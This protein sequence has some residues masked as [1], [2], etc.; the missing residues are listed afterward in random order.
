MSEP[1]HIC[2]RCGLPVRYWYYGWKHSGGG[3][4]RRSCGQKP[5]PIQL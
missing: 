2:A 3:G 1:T 5:K 4:S